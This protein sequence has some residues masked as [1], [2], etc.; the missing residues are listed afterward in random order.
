M[1]DLNKSILNEILK[2]IECWQPIKDGK[3]V[4]GYKLKLPYVYRELR[5]AKEALF[6]AEIY[7][8]RT[9]RIMRLIKSM[10]I[11]PGHIGWKEMEIGMNVE[12]K[13]WFP[14]TSEWQD[15]LSDRFEPYFQ[16]IW[17][18]E[19]CYEEPTEDE[20]LALGVRPDSVMAIQEKLF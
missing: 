10:G 9:Q 4:T 2:A 17:L 20:I 6:Y 16:N 8:P 1:N 19:W 12:I 14:C 13:I 11:I 5:I 18:N 15:F 7:F 3:F